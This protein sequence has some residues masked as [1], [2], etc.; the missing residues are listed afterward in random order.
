LLSGQLWHS[1]NVSGVNCVDPSSGMLS[2]ID[3]PVDGCL[4]SFAFLG[5]S[6]F[7]LPNVTVVVELQH[8]F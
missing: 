3:F 6:M 2:L 8:F 1:F 7:L 5:L 4:L